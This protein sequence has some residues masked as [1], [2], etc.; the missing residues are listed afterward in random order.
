MLD[1]FATPWDKLDPEALRSF[2]KTAGEEGV[3]WEA[4]ADDERGPLRRDS[5]RKAA[6]GLANRIGGYILIGAKWDK[7][8]KCWRL[9]GIT[10]P[11]EEPEL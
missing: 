2:L 10:P 4:K 3:T 6:S 7:T 8:A 9:P 11:D 5:L 1:L